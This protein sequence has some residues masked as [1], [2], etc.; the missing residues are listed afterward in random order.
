MSQH[1]AAFK[2]SALKKGAFSGWFGIANKICSL[3]GVQV[4]ILLLLALIEGT[5]CSALK[6]TQA[7]QTPT[8]DSIVRSWKKQSAVF[9]SCRFELTERQEVPRAWIVRKA[10]RYVKTNKIDVGSD[11]NGFVAAETVSKFYCDGDKM[12]FEI[13]GEIPSFSS[14]TLVAPFEE[15]G[16]FDAYQYRSVETSDPTGSRTQSRLAEGKNFVLT[17][18]PLKPLLWKLRMNDKNIGIAEIEKYTVGPARHEVDG[19]SLF[20]LTEPI[21]ESGKNEQTQISVDPAQDYAIVRVKR[22]DL[23]TGKINYQQDIGYVEDSVGGWIPSRWVSIQPLGASGAGISTSTITE[24]AINVPISESLFSLAF[25]PNT[26]LI[27]GQGQRISL[28][29]GGR[30]WFIAGI[31]L[32]IVLV[33]LWLAQKR[34]SLSWIRK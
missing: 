9:R 6:A 11:A 27:N 34:L 33:S 28:Q 31:A 25:P 14:K 17:H 18:N 8:I 1:L 12:R 22:V 4:S 29:N 13:R 5:F 24:Y 32:L 3:R 30:A 2:A 15:V 7:E 23:K 20:V 10:K 19:R 16:V 26:I 21:A